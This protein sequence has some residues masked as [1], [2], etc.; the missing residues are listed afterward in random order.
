MRAPPPP[1]SLVP[2]VPQA[3]DRLILVAARAR[4]GR[5]PHDAATVAAALDR[6]S[7]APRASTCAPGRASSA[8]DRELERLRKRAHAGL[9]RRRAHGRARAGEP[10]IGKTT[11]LDALAAEAVQPR[12][13]R[14]A[15]ARRARGPAVRRLAPGR[16]R[17][18][19]LAP[20]SPT[21]RSAPLLGAAASRRRGA[22][23]AAL[24]RRRGPARRRRGRRAAADRARRP[25]LGRR[26]V[27][28][29]ARPRRR[30]RAGCAGGAPTAGEV[31]SPDA[32]RRSSATRAPSGS[33][34]RG[35]G[36]GGRARA[37]AGRDRAAERRGRSTSARRG[38]P[39]YVAELVRLLAAEGATARRPATLVPA[40]VREVVRR[41]VERL[42]DGHAARVLEV[43]AV[44][45]RFTIADLVRAASVPP[46]RRWPRRSTAATRP[47]SS[48]RR[49][50]GPLHLRARDRPRRG[51]RRAA[52][53]AARRGARGRRAALIVRRDAG[54]DV[55]AAQIA[56]HALAAARA[57]RRPAARLGAAALEARARRRPR[58]A[59]PRPPSTTP[60][61]SRRS[62]S[63]PRRRPRAP[64]GA[65]SRWPRRRSRPA[66]SRRP[67]ALRAGRG[68][69]RAATA[70]RR[71]W[72]GRRSGSR[73]CRPY[74]ARRRGERSSCSRP[75]AGARC[76]DAPGELRAR[77]TGLLAGRL[78]PPT[79]RAREALIDEARRDGP[80]GSATRRTLPWLQ[81]SAVIDR[82]AAG[83]RRRPRRAPPRRSS[84]SP[85]Q[86]ADHGVAA[87]GPTCSRSATRCRT[88][89]IAARR[90]AASTARG[91]SRAPRRRSYPA[92]VPVVVEAAW[93]TF[94]GPPRRGASG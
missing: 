89:T 62:R 73:R 72:P 83:V 80:H 94:A 40:R 69:A 21:R 24:R 10:G 11:L 29:A 49:E 1:S 67:P 26:L 2:G 92:L 19:Q 42:G 6:R 51:A 28:A 5:P 14:A 54:A 60:T 79:S 47:G 65:C 3:L 75:G 77:V 45:G 15:R 56:H 8:A 9:E 88:A 90:G 39:F 13:R 53:A 44:A 85:A 25:A 41:R 33:S 87:C 34:S 76:Q 46:R 63:A 58:S 64:R 50:P 52:R 32:W 27:A 81:P 78:T 16:A 7:R 31:A 18:R 68:R 86:H 57:R 22:A 61:R 66:T 71:R 82:L 4:P 48:P 12:R 30:R 23:A 84:G 20:A 70:T 17:A 35:L 43:G 74:G 38:N 93:A 59:T 91:R 55:P 37:P 36:A